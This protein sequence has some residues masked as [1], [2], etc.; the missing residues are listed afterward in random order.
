[1]KHGFGTP[2]LREARQLLALVDLPTA[3]LH[4]GLFKNFVA[5]YD[6][7]QP[8]ALG[9]AEVFDGVALLRSVATVPER[10]RQAFAASI[11]DAVEQRLCG[12][13]VVDVYLLTE[14]AS[15]YFANRGYRPVARD[16]APP[17]IAASTQYTT[18][19]PDSAMLMHK[20]LGAFDSL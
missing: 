6:D 5:F 15:A 9:G 3:D 7:F 14:T 12:A 19:C 10:R 2:T 18:L 4:D 13:G 11:I 20:A 16:A 17:A 1:M 8:V